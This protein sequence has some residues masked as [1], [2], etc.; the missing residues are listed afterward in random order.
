MSAPGYNVSD[1]FGPNAKAA[2]ANAIA[3]QPSTVAARKKLPP[4]E[5]PNRY[6]GVDLSGAN[7]A[8][9]N[10]GLY[11][12]TNN[13]RSSTTG[14]FAA[15]TPGLLSTPGAYENWLKA[16]QGQFDAP[17]NV[18]NLYSSGAGNIGPSPLSSLG[19][20]DNSSA[21]NSWISAQG[22]GP[23][24][25]SSAGV[26][27]G[28]GSGPQAAM[29]LFNSGGP[30]VGYSAGIANAGVNSQ[31]SQGLLASGQPAHGASQ[32]V[33]NS[34]NYT[35]NSQNALSQG[36]PKVDASGRVLAA[37][38]GNTLNSQK[39][40]S[41]GRPDTGTSASVLGSLDTGPS[42]SSNVYRGASGAL[43]GEGAFEQ[44]YQQN[45]TAFNDPNAGE[46]FYNQYG[47][48][49]MELSDT[50]KLYN[51][52]LGQLDPY[53][54]YAE[55]RAIQAAQTASAARGGFNSGL[56][57]QQESDISG[58]LR[59]QQAQSWVNLA[60]Q[61]DQARLA[62]YGQGEQFAQDANKNYNERVLNAFGLANTAQ[63]QEQNRYD[64]LSGIASRGDAADLGRNTLRVTAANNIDQN[65][66]G[67]YTAWEGA[68]RAADDSANQL[69]STKVTAANNIDN[70]S[71]GAYNA[72][73]TRANNADTQANNMFQTR[74]N[75]A[76]NVDQ[77]SINAYNAYAGVAANADS[78]AN[79]LY[80]NRV[81]ASGNADT[82]SI[83][84]F[85]SMNTAASNADRAY[86]DNL[87][88]RGN[89]ASNADQSAISAFNAGSGAQN[90]LATQRLN[91]QT[92]N[93]A[94]ATAQDASTRNNAV[95]NFNLASSADNAKYGR[96]G[97]QGG[98]M[99]DL[100]STGQNRLAGGLSANAGLSSQQMSLVQNILN[101]TA[102]IDSM[103][104]VQ[105]QALA[106]K[107]GVTLEQ[108]KAAKADLGS[109][110]N[111][112]FNAG[113]TLAKL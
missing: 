38:A 98:M 13:P 31:N 78:S 20:Q 46:R 82:A 89:I 4:A 29:Q 64:T 23:S 109:A 41:S 101:N 65:N 44:M 2:S 99:Q 10:A 43:G 55:K 21:Y 33:L 15:P 49:P 88:T 110:A 83:G 70:N 68:A 63:T 39:V 26:L 112:G 47:K 73:S 97:A 52:G 34:P 87:S 100:Q 80:G 71:I 56:A 45:G 102:N 37:G 69:F 75:I 108:F 57:A 86:N 74:G 22:G 19:S 30:S 66:I 91:Q 67:A 9:N 35:L 105:L 16:N 24:A 3:L 60:P 42:N 40:F 93:L 85:N 92:N 107:A 7:T 1:L 48:D 95:T 27:A 84:A 77:N 5:D 8:A 72:Y 59:G 106:D 103:S 28:A 90:N 50:E 62:R 14:S 58:N 113:T 79:T 61:A 11:A 53:Y 18:E 76:N 104:D 36:A 94:T 54:D 6:N 81:T 51:S 17:S 25:G 32:G 12:A 111:F 96:I